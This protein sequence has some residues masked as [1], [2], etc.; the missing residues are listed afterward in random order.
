M[1]SSLT[2]ARAA[3]AHRLK[4]HTALYAA[5]DPNNVEQRIILNSGGS[6]AGR[7][8]NHP[9]LGH[10]LLPIAYLEEYDM[11]SARYVACFIP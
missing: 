9:K 2:S 6:K 4:S 5:L 3:D 1:N 8:F 7:G 10:Y 11:D